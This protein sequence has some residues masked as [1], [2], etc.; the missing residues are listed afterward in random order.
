ME[1]DNAKDRSMRLRSRSGKASFREPSAF[2]DAVRPDRI[3]LRPV[4]VLERAAIKK[5]V[6][7]PGQEQFAGSVDAVFD[8]LQASRYPDQEHAFA[9]VVSKKT[10]GFF[11]L[12]EK[13]ALPGWAPRGAVTLHSFRI[14][15]ACQGKGFGRAGVD[16]A[17]SWV[18]RNRPDVE[19]LMLAVNA[20]NVPAKSLYLKAGFVDTGSI[21]RGAIGDQH[22]LT[23][24]R[25]QR[26][27]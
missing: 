16:L 13:Q 10:V 20:R 7:D 24:L 22:I 15:S 21:F 18:R 17:I 8:G 9:I 27:G 23:F 14:S 5:L 26:D 12:R 19:Q 6:L 11:I 3:K 25:L 1:R 2:P 4:T